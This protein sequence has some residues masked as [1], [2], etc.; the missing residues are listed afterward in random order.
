MPLSAIASQVL[1]VNDSEIRAAILGARGGMKP[2][3]AADC[4]VVNRERVNGDLDE[5]DAWVRNRGRIVELP[6]LG[7]PR[8]TS[9]LVADR[10]AERMARY[11]VVMGAAASSAVMKATSSWSSAGRAPVGSLGCMRM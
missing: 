7:S 10:R 6:G 3:S 1:L 9:W 5:V 8:T 4:E 2:F 11:V